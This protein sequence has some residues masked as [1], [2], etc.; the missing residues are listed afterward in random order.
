LLD[1][2]FDKRE[3]GE[4]KKKEI[5]KKNLET[6]R[7]SDDDT[8]GTVEKISTRQTQRHQ[9]RSSTV[10]EVGHTSYSKANIEPKHLWMTRVAHSIQRL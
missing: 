8:T 7:N 5:K 1:I 4:R 6:H 10:T 3:R 2:K 9:E